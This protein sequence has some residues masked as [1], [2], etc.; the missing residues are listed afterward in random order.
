MER[1]TH[2]KNK[3]IGDYYQL[4]KFQTFADEIRSTNDED[5]RHKYNNKIIVIDEV[6]NLR[7]QNEK[8]TS[9]VVLTR[10]KKP[11]LHLYEQYWRLSPY[12]Q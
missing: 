6:H 10:D 1:Q 3:M 8:G 9:E 5:L 12:C 11:G 4:G 2:R 7:I